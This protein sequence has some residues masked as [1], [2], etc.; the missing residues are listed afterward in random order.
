MMNKDYW[1]KQMK[2]N[3]DKRD[4]EE[5]LRK[6]MHIPWTIETFTRANEERKNAASA[7]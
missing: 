2:W 7:N 4:K 5:A 6:E 3:K 1:E